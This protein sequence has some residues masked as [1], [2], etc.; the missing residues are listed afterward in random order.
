MRDSKTMMHDKEDAAK[1]LAAEY[2]V[3]EANG[4]CAICACSKKLA[5][6]FTRCTAKQKNVN[7]LSFCYLWKEKAGT[8]SIQTLELGTTGIELS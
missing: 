3:R 2:D 7:P 8:Q 6:G 1:R 4:N 5:N